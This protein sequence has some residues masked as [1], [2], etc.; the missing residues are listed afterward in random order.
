MAFDDF[1]QHAHALAD[2]QPFDP[3]LTS[4]FLEEH[5]YSLPVGV[6]S[7]A[8]VAVLSAGTACSMGDPVDAVAAR[9][10]LLALIEAL[11]RLG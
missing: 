7:K 5:A 1:I 2:A 9:D 3:E 4:T 11:E 10:D 8:R 6:G